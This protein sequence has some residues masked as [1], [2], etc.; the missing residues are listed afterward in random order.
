MM[1]GKKQL[2]VRISDSAMALADKAAFIFHKTKT[3][4]IEEAIQEYA[5]AHHIAERY[6]LNIKD[7]MLVLIKIDGD[8]ATIVEMEVLNGVAPEVIAQRY[9]S[10]FNQDVPLV[11]DKK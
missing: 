8:A 11:V 9:S 7:G 10:R 4:V 6:Q 3:Q 2:N 5:K 1:E